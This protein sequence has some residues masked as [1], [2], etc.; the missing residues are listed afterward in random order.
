MR[1]TLL[2]ALLLIAGA[3]PAFADAV[4]EEKDRALDAVI[5]C[6]KL[7]D[8]AARLT[9]YDKAIGRIEEALAP[10]TPEEQMVDFGRREPKPQSAP[11][12]AEKDDGFSILGLEIIGPST[13]DA[14]AP[15]STGFAPIDRISSK[16]I[17][18]ATTP[19]GKLIVFLENGHVW[20][21][22]DSE[23]AHVPSDEEERIVTIKEASLGSYLMKIGDAN[24]TYRVRRVK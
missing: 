10:P 4:L 14:A 3:A 11:P 7:T 8:A 1:R 2:G 24:R 9:C 21:Q 20:R 23:R 19:D 6:S 15:A 12:P 18:Y 5:Q 22:I 16:I 13:P 17:D